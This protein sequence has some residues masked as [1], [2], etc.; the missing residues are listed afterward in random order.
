[1]R[2][3]TPDRGILTFSDLGEVT[4]HTA[5]VGALAGRWVVA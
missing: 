1:M 4:A 2:W 5:A 3:A